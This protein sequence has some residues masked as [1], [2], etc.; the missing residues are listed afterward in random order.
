MRITEETPVKTILETHPET[1]DVF[2]ANGFS[3]MSLPQ[4]KETAG[5]FTKLKTL[6]KVHNM[7]TELFLYHLEKKIL[8]TENERVFLL[9]D[10]Q[11]GEKLDFYGNTIC[12]LKFTFKD[13]L[14]DMVK[15]RFQKDGTVRNCYV[16]SGRGDNGFCDDIWMGTH[17]KTFPTLVFS[18]EFNQYLGRHF[19]NEMCG[20]GYFKTDFYKNVNPKIKEAGILDDQGDF[21]VYGVMAD[22]FLVDK[23]Q[24]EGLP[25]PKT[26]ADLLNP[27][28]KDKIVIFGKQ[29]DEVSNATLLYIQKDY[30][31]EGLKQFA[32]NV[33]CA[34][35]GS[36]MSKVAGTN[37]PEAGAIYIVSGFFA[38]TCMK[39]DLEIVWPEDGSMVLPMYMLVQKEG[40]SAIQDIADYITG[41]Q[42]GKACVKAYTPAVNG[43]V[44]CC[45]PD[46]AKLKWIGWDYI[47]NHDMDALAKEADLIFTD[48][49]IKLHPGQELLR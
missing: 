23:G 41:T 30:G 7:N 29:M 22:I 5:T 16:E 13:A 24:L 12:P 44:P 32:H 25:I 36:T 10:F 14:E 39:G 28:Y 47:R 46:T 19:M 20:K 33:K 40:F 37:R 35:H 18:K 49:W 4:L 15:A 45:I 48:E 11:P 21:C 26:T 8:D 1:F 3:G 43:D 34:L 6:L 31:D 27:I 38:N 17:I 42:F 2:L 9:D